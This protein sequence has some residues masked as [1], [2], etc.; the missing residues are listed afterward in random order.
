MPCGIKI[1][2]R[3]FASSW[4]S[5]FLKAT[6]KIHHDVSFE[7]S[8]D[9]LRELCKTDLVK[10]TDIKDNPE[11]FFEAHRILARHA[12]SHGPGFWVRFTVHYNLCMGT[13]LAL[14]TDEQVARIDDYQKGGLLG[15]FALTE[16][17]AGVQSGLVVQTTADWD[18]EKQKFIINTPNEGARKNWISQGFTADKAVVIADLSVGGQKVGP[19]A[20][21]MDFRKEGKLVPGISVDDMGRKTVG[22]DLDNAWIAFDKV[23]LDKSV[24]C[25]RMR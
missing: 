21:I 7:E 25:Y 5:D 23:E 17:L 9:M 12:T 24:R 3:A 15:C 2:R 14:G 6:E 22:N 13:I 16:K 10:A 8:A 18:E 1:A 11:R 20:F 19:H 4:T